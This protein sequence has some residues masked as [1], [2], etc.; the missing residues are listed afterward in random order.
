MILCFISMNWI[1]NQ[2]S[3]KIY[4]LILMRDW[5]NRS[6]FKTVFPV[7]AF[8]W[9]HFTKDAGCYQ[10]L[11]DLEE[12]Q[13]SIPELCVCPHSG[14]QSLRGLNSSERRR[15]YACVLCIL[16]L[17]GTS[18]N[19]RSAEQSSFPPYHSTRGYFYLQ[20]FHLLERLWLLII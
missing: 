2:I 16:R 13:Y 12:G 7:T 18:T 3:E 5:E 8:Q 20:Q 15:T 9:N 1:N 11:A 14:A 4:V 10:I 6:V 19:N 17:K